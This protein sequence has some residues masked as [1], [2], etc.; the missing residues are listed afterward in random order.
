L[1]INKFIIFFFILFFS[2]INISSKKNNKN[3][4][5]LTNQSPLISQP[6]TE[7]PLGTIKADGWLKK[8]LETMANGMTGN[9]DSVY[10]KVIGK[11]N[12]WLGGD[13]DGWERGPYWLDGLVPLAYI[14]D[15]KK[16]IEK[17]KPWIEWSLN[18]QQENGYF[19]P[20][21]FDE[22]PL[23]EIGLQKTNRKDW[24]PHMVMLKVLKQYY[25]ATNDQRVIDLMTKYFKYQLKELPNTPLDNW[26][27]WGNRRGGDNLLIVYWLYNI[28][29]EP[30]LLELS[31]ILY[32]QTHPW[33]EHFLKGTLIN[34]NS[35]HCVNLAQGMKQPIIYYQQHPNEKYIKA[36]QKAL[37]DL[38][39]HHGQPQGMYG[40]DEHLHGNNPNKGSE[41]CSTT[42]LM[43]SLE[44]MIAITGDTDFADHLELITFNALPA[45]A[46]DD[47]NTRQYFQSA[48]QVMLTRSNRNFEMNHGH[49]ATDVVFGKFTGYTCCTANMHQGWPKFTQNLWYATSDNGLAALVYS[50]SS[51]NAKVGNGVEIK[52][53]EKTNYPFDDNIKLHFESKE[54]VQFPL[55]LR[56]PKWCDSPSFKINGKKIKF[57]K[58]N[59]IV[60]IDRKWKNNDIVEIRFPMNISISRWFENSL[61]VERGPL[62]YALKIDEEWK[63]IKNK[64]DPEIYGEYYYEVVPKSDWNYGI[65][66]NYDKGLNNYEIIKKNTSTLSPW[67][68]DNAPI[69]IKVAAKKI[70]EWKLYNNTPGPIPYS[71]LSEYN[72]SGYSTKVNNFPSLEPVEM[73]SLIPYGC[74]TLRI[75]EF[76]IVR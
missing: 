9:L 43:Y 44:K 67:N 13:G 25:T 18:N 26:T 49:K 32:N 8:Q 46:S 51:V 29:K 1:K 36:V 22:K 4:N 72:N 53:T 24:W 21:P 17:I 55:H 59:N 3:T 69:E 15:D 37:R 30:F 33:T 50:P 39:N 7:L 34:H 38:K 56:I 71:Q 47:F 20:I 14:L 70:N 64:K 11:R 45:Q 74:T 19:G 75:T 61:A 76:P 31:E 41:F 65:L 68:I 12:G 6:Y 63:K 73:I 40:A 60:I 62:V 58:I 5:Y 35:F 66:Y 54:N 52:I 28:T 48:N 57:N 2:I 27:Y 10:E 23:K 16:L 42:E